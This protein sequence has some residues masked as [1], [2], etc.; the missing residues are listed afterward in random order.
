MH[1]DRWV[2][3]PN[4]DRPGGHLALGNSDGE[5]DNQVGTQRSREGEK[6]TDR[7]RVLVSFWVDVYSY[8]VVYTYIDIQILDFVCIHWKFISV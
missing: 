1:P 5:H 3:F 7:D 4:L 6:K 8:F 2:R